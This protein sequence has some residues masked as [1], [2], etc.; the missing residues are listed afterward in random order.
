MVHSN[1]KKMDTTTKKK[2]KI[3]LIVFIIL[4]IPLGYVMKIM[5]G[6]YLNDKALGIYWGSHVGMTDK[7]AANQANSEFDNAKRFYKKN[8][9]IYINQARL[10]GSLKQY[11][12]AIKTIEEYIEIKPD[13]AY[14]HLMLGV[15][16][17]L[18]N[19]TEKAHDCYLKF[20]SLQAEN[21]AEKKLNSQELKNMKVQKLIDYYL[22]NDTISFKL[23]LTELEK[24]YPDDSSI[25]SVKQWFE[26]ENRTEIILE[27]IGIATPHI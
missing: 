27:Y 20:I 5:Y 22:L 8:K 10:Y 9:A 1:S 3:V 24:E 4:L 12:K 15:F 2:L 17:E 11:D 18:Q 23:T 21:Y 26:S 13:F 7:E 19:E 14:G 16:S 6:M 25:N